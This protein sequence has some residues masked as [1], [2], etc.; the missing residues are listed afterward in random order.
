MTKNNDGRV[1]KFTKYPIKMF[2][3]STLFLT[4]GFFIIG[5]IIIFGGVW[6]GS[7]V[8]SEKIPD[9]YLNTVMAIGLPCFMLSC[10][11]VIIRK[12]IPRLG[13][14]SIRGGFAVFQGYLGLI[15]IGITWIYII[16]L[17]LG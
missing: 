13:L 6:L 14:P 1:N 12:E 8:Y 10:L 2:F 15:I 4:I 17:I 5:F 9:R 7:H 3:T 11:F 16:Y